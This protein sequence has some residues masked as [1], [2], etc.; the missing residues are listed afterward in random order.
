MNDILN[1]FSL[2]FDGIIEL[3]TGVHKSKHYSTGYSPECRGT[4]ISSSTALPPPPRGGT[5]QSALNVKCGGTFVP[6]PN[7][8]PPPLPMSLIQKPEAPPIKLFR[9]D[10][11]KIR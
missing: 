5:G 10:G 9:E 3:L 11:K 8:P 7:C 6:S 2:I 4:Y 1:G